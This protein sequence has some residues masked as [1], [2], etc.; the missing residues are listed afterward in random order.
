MLQAGMLWKLWL[1]SETVTLGILAIVD[2]AETTRQKEQLTKR[3]QLGTN[4]HD[5]RAP[6]GK[7]TPS[8][9]RYLYRSLRGVIPLDGQC[10]PAI[11]RSDSS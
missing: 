1:L 9:D 3:G 11:G 5:P 4:A 8:D 10:R 6:V 7:A 2:L